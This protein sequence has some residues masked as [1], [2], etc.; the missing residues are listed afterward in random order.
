MAKTYFHASE[1]FTASYFA[2]MAVL[3][4]AWYTYN[5]AFLP[6]NAEVPCA[7]LQLVL[8]RN[9]WSMWWADGDYNIWG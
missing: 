8:G 3:W 1:K 2:T 6:L 9:V 4:M 7:W 5:V